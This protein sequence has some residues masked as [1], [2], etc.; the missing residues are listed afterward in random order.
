MNDQLKPRGQILLSEQ[1]IENRIKE[2]GQQITVLWL[3][4][5]C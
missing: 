5:L 3:E 1:Q 4:H 2:L